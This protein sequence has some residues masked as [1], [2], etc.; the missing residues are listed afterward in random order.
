MVAAE[1]Q[2]RPRRAAAVGDAMAVRALARMLAAL[3]GLHGGG[4]KRLH[5]PDRPQAVMALLD[6]E[7]P[8]G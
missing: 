5:G 2:G 4:W 3:A 8:V 6:A 7:A 1:K